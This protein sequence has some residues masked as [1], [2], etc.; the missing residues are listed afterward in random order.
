[1]TEIWEQERPFS[2]HVHDVFF[3][4][5]CQTQSRTGRLP[6][7]RRKRRHAPVLGLE[8]L[9][10]KQLGAKIRTARTLFQ[11]AVGG[12]ALMKLLLFN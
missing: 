8:G 2:I 3:F 10:A 4:S 5:P 9:P 12:I 11:R 6:T 7:G 1:M